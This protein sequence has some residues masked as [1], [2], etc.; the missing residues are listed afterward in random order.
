MRNK[1]I[2]ITT[3]LLLIA[4]TLPVIAGC[5]SVTVKT[6][7]YL[8]MALLS[9]HVSGERGDPPDGASEAP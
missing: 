3:V 1:R 2:A 6:K 7:Q 5:D 9:A 8:G 4:F